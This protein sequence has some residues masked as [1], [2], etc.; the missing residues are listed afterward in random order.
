MGDTIPLEDLLAIWALH[1]HPGL[2]QDDD[3]FDALLTLIHRLLQRAVREERR[4]TTR[5]ML[6]VVPC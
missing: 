1:H 4:A 2:L 6:R 3:L 5:R